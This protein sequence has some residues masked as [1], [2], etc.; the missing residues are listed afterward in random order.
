M[1]KNTIFTT[2]GMFPKIMEVYYEYDEFK[3]FKKKNVNQNKR[4]KHFN[5]FHFLSKTHFLYCFL[6]FPNLSLD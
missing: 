2:V 4:K 3:H 1:D 6:C 5:T